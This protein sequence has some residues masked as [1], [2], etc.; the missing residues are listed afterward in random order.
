MNAERDGG[1]K[2]HA[3][4]HRFAMLDGW[5]ALSILLVLAGHL[6]PIAV[7]H[8]P[9]N[10][11]VAAMGMVLFFI[12]SGFLITRFL[13]QPGA[14]VRVF[15]IRRFFRIVPLAWIGMAIGLWMADSASLPQWVAN[16][17]FYANLPPFYIPRTAGHLWSLCVEMQFYVTI[18]L[19]VALLGRRGLYL[20]PVLALGVTGLRVVTH[21]YMSIVT[22]VRIDEIL[23]G[24]TLA[25]AYNG[26]F[27]AWPMRLLGRLNVYLLFPVLLLACHPLGGPLNYL[28]P[29]IA[30]AMVGSTLVN[31]PPL[32]TRLFEHR[33]AGYVATTSYAIY[34]IHGLLQ[35][36]WVGGGDKLHKYLKRP[37]LLLLTFGLAHISTFWF[38]RPCIAFA[39]RLTSR[40]TVRV[41]A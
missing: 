36:S 33:W 2:T 26:W 30:A 1:T 3:G 24:A 9:L 18:A 25:L 32:L 21:T 37:L 12:L 23:A 19:L 39:K 40:F 35:N 5:R 28:R 34:I 17:L 27:G 8:V 13:A 11:A 31:A 7:P 15:I 29:Y 22:W 20:I 41:P 10:A 6:F 14:D 16:Y 38:E 4:E